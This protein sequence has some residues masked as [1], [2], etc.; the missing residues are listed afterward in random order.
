MKVRCWPQALSYCRVPR[1]R[2]WDKD[3]SVRG[4]LGDK[5]GKRYEKGESEGRQKRRV[6]SRWLEEQ[7][8]ALTAGAA[9]RALWETGMDLEFPTEE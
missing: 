5:P 3:L 6:V 1:S 2:L 4:C 8:A 7:V 9:P